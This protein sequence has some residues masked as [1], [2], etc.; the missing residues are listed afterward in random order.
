MFLLIPVG[1]NY[2]TQ[3]LPTITFVL[4][5]LNVAIY[6]VT[7]GCG[8][9]TNDD[10]AKWVFDNLW[11]TPNISHAHTYLTSMFVHEGFFHLL[12]NMV[13]LFLFGCCVEDVIGRWKYLAFYL[14]AGVVAALTHIISSPERFASVIPL[15]GASG[16]VTA[17]IAGFLVL[18]SKQE[19]EFKYF[20]FLFLRVFSGDFSVAAWIVISFWFLRDLFFMFLSQVI[21]SNGGGVAFAAHVGGFLWGIALIG[22]YK[23]L[24]KTSRKAE[25][26]VPSWNPLMILRNALAKVQEPVINEAPTIFLSDGRA[27]SGP[28]TATQIR[29]MI[30]L[31]SISTEAQ[32]WQDGMT[33]WSTVNDF[34]A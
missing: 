17:C 14:S 34:T 21:G 32:Y 9:F 16:A 26:A 29:E 12:G 23:L 33:E 13:Y 3:R 6:L 20:G 25:V 5:G 27:E 30:S 7:L 24:T 4:M 1:V 31:G 8:G 11:L 22:L 10:T 2:E 18:F 15:G 28:F 19:I